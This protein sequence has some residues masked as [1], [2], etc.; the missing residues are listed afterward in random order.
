[1]FAEQKTKGG[2]GR[3]VT[4]RGNCLEGFREGNGKTGGI[5]GKGRYASGGGG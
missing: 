1:V 2:S 5:L 4:R 3:R